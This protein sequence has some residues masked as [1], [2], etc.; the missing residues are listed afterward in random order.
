MLQGRLGDLRLDSDPGHSNCPQVFITGEESQMLHS[1]LCVP[2]FL[3]LEDGC[4][5]KFSRLPKSE[6]P[7]GEWLRI[8]IN[9][10]NLHPSWTL[11][12][13]FTPHCP[14]NGR[15]R[16]QQARSDEVTGSGTL[17]SLGLLNSWSL[18]N[19]Q[20]FKLKQSLQPC[21]PKDLGEG[22][23]CDAHSPT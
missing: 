9:C 3:C 15:P 11:S 14:P 23:L 6:D 7:L 4:S 22:P 5:P 13:I 12:A 10:C 18:I 1:T 16:Q 17:P 20:F 21:P 8:S 2:P 19:A